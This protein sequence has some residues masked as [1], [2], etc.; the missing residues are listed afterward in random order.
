MVGGRAG[1]G[2]GVMDDLAPT[3]GCSTDTGASLQD[4][5]DVITGGAVRVFIRPQR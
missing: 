4:R 1:G 5:R 2:G 3:D